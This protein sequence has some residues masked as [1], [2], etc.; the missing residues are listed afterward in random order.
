MPATVH[1]CFGFCEAL[2]VKSFL[3]DRGFAANIPDEITPDYK[4]IIFYNDRPVR[5][6]VEESDFWDAQRALED[7]PPR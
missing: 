5:V 3:E 6:Q 2:R 4:A 7:F 1:Q